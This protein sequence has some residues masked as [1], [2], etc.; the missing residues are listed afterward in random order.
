[1]IS[2]RLLEEE[3]RRLR[4]LQLMVELTLQLISQTDRLTLTEGLDYIQN[5]RNFALSLFPNKGETFD[6]IYKPR[7]IRVLK[8]RGILKVSQN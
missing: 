1:M 2:R 6:L 7:F 3:N 5:A 8:E 4:Q